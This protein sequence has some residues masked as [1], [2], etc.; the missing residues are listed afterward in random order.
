MTDGV[1]DVTG[2]ED[3]LDEGKGASLFAELTQLDPTVEESAYL[4]RGVWDVPGLL[5]DVDIMRERAAIAEARSQGPR[6]GE[7]GIKRQRQ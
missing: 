7:L 6:S 2:L 4:V 1:W 5:D 3:D